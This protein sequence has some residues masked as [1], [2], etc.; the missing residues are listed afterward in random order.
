LVVRQQPAAPT[1]AGAP[2]SAAAS[3]K[4]DSPILQV[5]GNVNFPFGER[6]EVPVARRTLIVR[7][8]HFDGANGAF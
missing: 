5:T 2:G 7:R 4:A 6:P 3:A 1:K 8:D